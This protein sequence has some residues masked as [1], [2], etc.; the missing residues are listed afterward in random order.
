MEIFV[1]TVT[2]KTFV[3]DVEPSDSVDNVK[4]KIQWKEGVPPA[5]QILIFAG[6]VL[7]D[8]RTLSDYNIQKES[9]LTLV[10]APSV[11]L[12]TTIGVEPPSGAGTQLCVLGPDQAIGQRIGVDAPGNYD[13]SLWSIGAV[14]WSV[15]GFAGDTFVATLAGGEVSSST[16][17]Q[18][19]VA[20]VVPSSVTT[21]RIE[22]LGAPLASP[23]SGPSPASFD[24]AA[25]D[26]VSLRAQGTSPSTTS[27]S[28][29][30]STSSTTTTV[31]GGASGK[32]GA[33]AAPR[34]T[35]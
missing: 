17:V 23:S 8:G 6:K 19:T 13:L 14:Q 15:A 21:V 22:L 7:E 9:T 34:F 11:S 24:I 33:V 31:P 29:S 16:M 5:Q 1:E 18:T 10:V 35:G 20:V 4:G 12:Y 26:L 32:A 2:G 25:I 27:S 3:L 28:T 30:S